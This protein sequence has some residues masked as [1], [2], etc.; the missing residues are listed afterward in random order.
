VSR[1]DIDLIDQPGFRAAAREALRICRREALLTALGI[2]AMHDK[3]EAIERLNKLIGKEGQLSGD[4]ARSE[5]VM[6]ARFAARAA[7]A[8]S[9]GQAAVAAIKRDGRLEAL[10]E[11]FA[12]VRPLGLDG[13][14]ARHNLRHELATQIAARIT[15]EEAFQTQGS[16]K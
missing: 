7:Q 4:N 6:E 5:S 13:N 15:R 3:A 1:D 10:R 12:L 8:K 2:I 16:D 11:V 14:K 9:D